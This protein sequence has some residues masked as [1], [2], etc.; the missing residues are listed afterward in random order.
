MARRASLFLVVPVNL[1]ASAKQKY[2]A[3]APTHDEFTRA[4]RASRFNDFIS[5]RIAD[6]HGESLGLRADAEQDWHNEIDPVK[7]SLLPSQLFIDDLHGNS[8][9]PRSYYDEA[10]ILWHACQMRINDPLD[11]VK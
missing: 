1:V 8:V 3:P 6:N 2:S 11:I 9:Y 5:S 10:C 7:P 4:Q